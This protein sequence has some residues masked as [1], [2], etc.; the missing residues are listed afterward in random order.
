[1]KKQS[2][3]SVEEDGSDTLGLMSDPEYSRGSSVSGEKESIFTEISP[4]LL[5]SVLQG[6]INYTNFYH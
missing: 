1:M 4:K 3:A 5:Q 6:V 2:S